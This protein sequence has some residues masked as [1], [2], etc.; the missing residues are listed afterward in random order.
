MIEKYTSFLRSNSKKIIERKKVLLLFFLFFIFLSCLIYIFISKNSVQFSEYSI[1]KD[2]SSKTYFNLSSKKGVLY[3]SGKQGEEAVLDFIKKD[4]PINGLGKT[5]PSSFFKNSTINKITK[6]SQLNSEYIS[7]SSTKEHYSFTQKIDG[8][9]VYGASLI[10]HLQNGN[11]IYSVSGNLV[12]NGK[13]TSLKIKSQDANIVALNVA[14]KE[15]DIKDLKVVDSK[16]TLLN[17]NILGISDD[18]V[19]YLVQQ[20]QVSSL[21]DNFST[22]YFVRLDSGEIIYKENLQQNVRQRNVYDCRNNLNP[23]SCAKVMEEGYPLS[24]ISDVDEIYKYMGDVYDYYWTNFK[25]DGLDGQGSPL[26]GFVRIYSVNNQLCRSKK[27]A[28]FNGSFASG[29]MAYC[30]GTVAKDITAHEFSHGV[31]NSTAGLLPEY[32]SLA[33]NE[34]IADS[35]AAALDKNWTMGEGSFLGVIRDMSNPPSIIDKLG[36]QPDKLFSNYDCAIEEE[37]HNAGIPNKAF[38]LMTVGGSFNGCSISGIG[39][40][41]SQQILYKTLASQYI[42]PTAN[43]YD[44]YVGINKAC[45]DLYGVGSSICDEVKKAY[46]ATEMD[47]QP[48]GSAKGAKCIGQVEKIATCAGSSPGEPIPTETPTATPIQ[49]STTKTPNATTAPGANPTSTPVPGSGSNPSTSPTGTKFKPV[50]SPTPTPD[51]YFSCK[52]DPN[53]ASRGNALQLC[54]LICSPI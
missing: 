18:P 52:P 23:V 1:S 11:E 2:E 37:H 29:F 16:K 45:E 10:V 17:F 50:E 32:Q 53:C 24:G 35:F 31:V 28:Y 12:K 36:P 7:N 15:S 6:D 5:L 20:V 44:M 22:R 48:V 26:E 49:T 21:S 43:F 9:P 13:I 38:Y 39:I 42:P 54:P 8:I 4:G 40:D 33:L 14:K 51:Q 3:R 47:Q 41:R 34:S 19:N 46:Q 30:E 25:R 27:N